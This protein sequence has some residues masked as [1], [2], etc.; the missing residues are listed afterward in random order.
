MCFSLYK[1]DRHHLHGR[2]RQ[3]LPLQKFCSSVL[4]MRYGP[5]FC[6][7]TGGLHVKKG[8]ILT[9]W[10][11]DLFRIPNEIYKPALRATVPRNLVFSICVFCCKA[12]WLGDKLWQCKAFMWSLFLDQTPTCFQY[13]TRL[14][15]KHGDQKDEDIKLSIQNLDTLLGSI[16]NTIGRKVHDH[17]QRT[18]TFTLLFHYFC[19]STRIPKHE[20]A[21]LQSF[22]EKRPL[23]ID[24]SIKLV[25]WLGVPAIGITYLP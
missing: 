16:V 4:K 18:K 8:I 13:M 9:L 1:Y 2:F 21:D 25:S 22:T 23:W 19:I 17:F 14:A 10:S 24:P 12:K 11:E 6:R 7:E 15:V 5:N 3:R 20:M